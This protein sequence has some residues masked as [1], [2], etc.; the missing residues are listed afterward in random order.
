MH[1]R[2]PREYL[3]ST[4]SFKAAA[5]NTSVVGAVVAT[6]QDSDG[7]KV[8]EYPA[9]MVILAMGFTG[10]DKVID[11][12]NILKRDTHSNFKAAYGEYQMEGSPWKNLFACGDCRKGASLV[13]T[14]IAE[15]RD[16]AARVDT[17]LMG[18]TSLPRAA[19]LAANPS[20]FQMPMRGDTQVGMVK[21][22]NRRRAKSGGIAEVSEAFERGLLVEP[23]VEEPESESM[24]ASSGERATAAKATRPELASLPE[25]EEAR[26]AAATAPQHPVAQAQ[27]PMW[28]V[29]G[30][31]GLTAVNVMLLATVVA[32]VATRPRS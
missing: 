16:C 26:A 10:P 32:L 4:K 22:R 2:D 9:D 13:V 29:A 12:Q 23:T 27:P 7:S 19:P 21:K 24:A 5:N 25:G 17:F 28:M 11:P 31:G 18:D 6:R 14:A 20:F 3:V 1:G 15:G 8:V 30:L